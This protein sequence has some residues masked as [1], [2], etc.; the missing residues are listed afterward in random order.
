M[1]GL[2]IKH[3]SQGIQWFV[4]AKSA[5][6]ELKRIHEEYSLN[7]S[8]TCIMTK[9]G[10]K[11]G[12]MGGL[13]PGFW[14]FLV[15]RRIGSVAVFMAALVA[16]PVVVLVPRVVMAEIAITVSIVSLAMGVTAALIQ[17]YKLQNELAETQRTINILT[18][19]SKHILQTKHDIEKKFLD[20]LKNMTKWQNDMVKHM[21]KET[22]ATRLGTVLQA[23]LFVVEQLHRFLK[24][25]LKHMVTDGFE[26][27]FP[28]IKLNGDSDINHWHA[29]QCEIR[30]KG[31]DITTLILKITIPKIDKTRRIL[32][33]DPSGRGTTTGPDSVQTEKDQKLGPKTKTSH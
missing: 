24:N 2:I 33:A 19:K 6:E 12:M 26:L 23:K 9:S 20:A 5:E 18:E 21:E 3:D 31:F 22:E 17:T 7:E 16:A 29:D 11:Y 4:P 32:K 25:F 8:A 10:K 30:K 14:S 1:D 13:G 15:F 28:G 27:L